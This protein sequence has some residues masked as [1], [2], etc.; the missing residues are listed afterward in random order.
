MTGADTTAGRGGIGPSWGGLLPSVVV[1]PT[2]CGIAR[3]RVI[4]ERNRE[5]SN[6]IGGFTKTSPYV[7]V[8][9][10]RV[11]VNSFTSA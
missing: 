8:S 5:L 2:Q 4:H 10:T 6:G 7:I 11:L 1:C 3:S 9:G